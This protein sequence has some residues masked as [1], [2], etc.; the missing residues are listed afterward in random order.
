MSTK[1]TAKMIKSE[2]SIVT[3]NARD[4]IKR[5]IK[6]QFGYKFICTVG[7]K[8]HRK[9]ETKTFAQLNKRFCGGLKLW[10]GDRK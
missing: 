2:G 1:I 5:V 8:V 9:I 4:I 10:D 7:F 6:T 3:Y